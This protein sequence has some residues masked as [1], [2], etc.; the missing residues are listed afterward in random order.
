MSALHMTVK[1]TAKPDAI[2]AIR[3]AAITAQT[4]SQQE[5]GCLSYQF[6]QD[7]KDPCV[8]FV[9]E[10]YADKEAF[11]AHA[12]SAHMA[13]YLKATEGLAESVAMHKVSPL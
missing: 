6:F 11:K 13:A 8:F 3:D 1:I 2:E 12:S 9:Q 4:A 10:S 7:L 5:A